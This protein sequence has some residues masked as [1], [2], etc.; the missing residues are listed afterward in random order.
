[1]KASQIRIFLIVILVMLLMM[2]TSRWSNMFPASSEAPANKQPQSVQMGQMKSPVTDDFKTVFSKAL[3]NIKRN[4]ITFSTD[5]F[6]NITVNSINGAITH[7]ALVRYPVSLKDNS[8]MSIFSTK[9]KKTYIAQGSVVINGQAESIVFDQHKLSHSGG[10]TTLQLMGDVDG[11]QVTRTYMLSDRAYVIKMTQHVAN[12]TTKPVTISF[13]NNFV[14]YYDPKAHSTSIL[15][16]HHF[17]FR[18]VGLSSTRYPYQKQTFSKLDEQAIDITTNK[19]W[20]AMVQHYFVSLWV[21]NNPGET[22][23]VYGRKLAEHYYQSGVKTAPQVLSPG[24]SLQN[25]N[26]LYVGPTVTKNLEAMVSSMGQNKPEGLN[27]LIDYGMLSF[28]SVIIFWLMSLIHTIVHNWG[29]AIILVTVVIKLIFYPLS[30]KSYRSMA[31]MRSLQPRLKHLQEMYKGDRQKYSRKMMELYR[32]EKVN[33]ASGCLPILIQIPVFIALY[34]VLLE[35]V[36]LRQAPF[37]LWIQDL[38]ARDPYYVLPILNGIMMFIQQKI[39][40]TSADPT[41]AKVMMF[42]PLI[43][44]VFFATFPSGLVLYWLTNS[45]VSV[46]QQWY[47]TKKYQQAEKV[48]KAHHK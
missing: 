42:M 28:I 29:V 45:A 33:P 14:Q 2:L 24:K 18:G 40:P 10:R 44:V 19:G 23:Q 47:I 34:W 26:L 36:Q 5:V 32:E 21:P 7:L 12:T 46:F 43:F 41:Q 25:N 16:A 20:A 38:S 1:M 22:F 37:L 8:P 35:S 30:A 4:S 39:S 6:S 13:N 9:A 31:K 27:K 11:I 48:R 3:S 17:S 15:S